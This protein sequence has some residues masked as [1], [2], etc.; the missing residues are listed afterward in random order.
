MYEGGWLV[1]SKGRL[2][3]APFTP[4]SVGFFVEPSSSDE[5]SSVAP[6][7]IGFLPLVEGGVGFR[8]RDFLRK[9][10]D[11]GTSS[12]VVSAPSDSHVHQDGVHSEIF[13]RRWRSQRGCLAQRRGW[14]KG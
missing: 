12:L 9:P 6:N 2:D 7:L 1:T 5:D 10:A 11:T 14:G 3:L 8:E 13:A 4:A